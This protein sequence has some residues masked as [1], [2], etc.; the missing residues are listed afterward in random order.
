MESPL[1]T[2]P[3]STPG[4]SGS[5]LPEFQLDRPLVVGATKVTGS[6]PVGVPIVIMDISYITEIGRG[7][8]NSKGQFSVE[9]DPPLREYTLIGIMLD[10]S[11]ESP[12]SKEQIPCG[13]NCRDQPLVGLLFDYAPVNQTSD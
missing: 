13:E 2:S 9:V 7:Q 1:V 4:S 6:G 10:E 3:V 11:R 12:Y 5:D 8:V